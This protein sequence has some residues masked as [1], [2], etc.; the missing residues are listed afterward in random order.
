MQVSA[1]LNI[2]KDEDG[3]SRTSFESVSRNV[4]PPLS[5]PICN[6]DI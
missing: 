3:T 2:N 6:R 1:P 4:G 5:V